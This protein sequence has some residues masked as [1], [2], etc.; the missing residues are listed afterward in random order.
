MLAQAF[1]GDSQRLSDLDFSMLDF[2]ASTISRTS[3]MV[4]SCW[5]QLAQEFWFMME[6]MA[7]CCKPFEVGSIASYVLTSAIFFYAMAD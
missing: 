6:W 4:A 7:R 2:L 5:S 1:L 3:Q